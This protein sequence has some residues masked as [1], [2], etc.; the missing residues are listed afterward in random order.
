MLG[1]ARILTLHS[2]QLWDTGSEQ[3]Y[4]KRCLRIVSLETMESVLAEQRVVR[5]SRSCYYCHM[6]LPIDGKPYDCDCSTEAKPSQV[7]MC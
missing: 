1:C 5:D 2:T 3:Y 6:A 4:C 7:D